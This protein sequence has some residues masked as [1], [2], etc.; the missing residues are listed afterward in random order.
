MEKACLILTIFLAFESFVIIA[1]VIAL[2]KAVEN[3]KINIIELNTVKE[4]NKIT[5]DYLN[6]FAEVSHKNIDIL[7]KRLIELSEFVGRNEE[8]INTIVDY[9][10][11]KYNNEN[12]ITEVEEIKEE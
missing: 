6:K 7:Y 5:L 8:Y 12:G 4:R 9:L 11:R 2:R 1:I 3:I 10:E